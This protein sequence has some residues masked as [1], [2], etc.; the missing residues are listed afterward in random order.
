MKIKMDYK[1]VEVE[2]WIDEDLVSN[3]CRDFEDLNEVSIEKLEVV[4]E[5]GSDVR[6]ALFYRNFGG[7]LNFPNQDYYQLNNVFRGK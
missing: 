4:A 5:S 6:M 7:E 1:T 2:I 3:F